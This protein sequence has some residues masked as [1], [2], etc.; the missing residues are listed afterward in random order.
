MRLKFL[1]L[2]FCLLATVALSRAGGQ[3]VLLRAIAT[4]DVT[5]VHPDDVFDVTLSLENPTNATQILKLPVANWDRIWK[6]SNRHVT[7]DAMNSGEG[8]ETTVEIAPHSTYEFPDV[9]KM[10]VDPDFKGTRVDFR[11]GFRT[12]IFGK[13][14]WSAPISLTVTPYPGWASAKALAR[15]ACLRSA[16]RGLSAHCYPVL[17]YPLTASPKDWPPPP[18][19]QSPCSRYPS[20]YRP[21]PCASFSASLASAGSASAPRS[22]HG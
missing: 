15:I 18:R 5:E 6:S 9:L 1:L 17:R 8:E 10:Y 7:W 16:P 21:T 13:I 14:V 4:T 12:T 22:A 2:A 19:L 3:A 11:M 20:Q